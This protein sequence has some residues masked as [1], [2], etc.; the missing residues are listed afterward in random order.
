MEAIG[1]D[2][3]LICVSAMAMAREFLEEDHIKFSSIVSLEEIEK[4]G[5][6]GIRRD[7]IIFRVKCY[8]ESQESTQG[9]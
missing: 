1:D 2:A 8:L 6:D 7:L 9:V 3:V 5:K 4:E